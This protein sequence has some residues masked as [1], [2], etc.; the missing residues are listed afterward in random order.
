MNNCGICSNTIEGCV[1][2]QCQG[3]C[4]HSFHINCLSVGNEFITSDIICLLTNIPGLSWNCDSCVP[5]GVML[6]KMMTILTECVAS[7]NQMKMEFSASKLHLNSNTNDNTIV[8]DITMNEPMNDEELRDVIAHINPKVDEQRVPLVNEGAT[9]S[10]NINIPMVE[11][12]GPET[13]DKRPNPFHRTLK[14]NLIA[15]RRRNLDTT[16][17]KGNGNTNK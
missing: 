15:K 7:V 2:L 14:K 8:G 12:S 17:N 9:T 4:G 16:I 13:P 10:M 11:N 1:H 3:E 5:V 6:G